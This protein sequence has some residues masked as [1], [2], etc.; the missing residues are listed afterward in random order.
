MHRR[1]QRDR[2]HDGRYNQQEG[3]LRRTWTKPSSGVEH[4]LGLPQT[5]ERMVLAGRRIFARLQSSCV[6][7]ELHPVVQMLVGTEFCAGIL[8]GYPASMLFERSKEFLSDL[9]DARVERALLAKIIE[10][11]QEGKR[12]AG[13]ADGGVGSRDAH[14]LREMVIGLGLDFWF[15]IRWRSTKHAHDD[16]L[17][18]ESGL[19]TLDN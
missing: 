12:E 11:C 4:V 16:L 10:A 5:G 6:F 8:S 19:A 18:C 2:D 7:G 3:R 1:R 14:D 17:C 13:I 9:R 15:R